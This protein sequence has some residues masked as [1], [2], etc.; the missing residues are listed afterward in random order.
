MS[1]VKLIFALLSDDYKEPEPEP[2][3]FE[4]AQNELISINDY[5]N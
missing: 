5:L 4:E 2:D 3:L 1:H